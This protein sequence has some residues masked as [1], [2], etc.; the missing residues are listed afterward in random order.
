[1]PPKYITANYTM[2]DLYFAGLQLEPN[3]TYCCT[4]DSLGGELELHVSE[5]AL[6]K[7]ALVYIPP[8]PVWQTH[9]F[10]FRLGDKPFS[11]NQFVN[12]GISFNKTLWAE[13][14]NGTVITDTYVDNVRIYKADD[15]TV[16]LVDGGDFEAELS[17][18]IYNRNWNRKILG[19]KGKGFGVT[20]VVDPLNP[21][22]HCLKIPSV[23]TRPT[24]S[25]SIGLHAVSF[26][27]IDSNPQPVESIVL[28]AQP[29]H[30][31][32]IVE[33]G[34]VSLG[35]VTVTK[36]HLLYFPPYS[37][38]HYRCQP[39]AEALYYWLTVDG[40]DADVLFAECGLTKQCV[41][42]ISNP[43]SL[44][45]R[46][47]EMLRVNENGLLQ[48]YE[49][50]AHLQLLFT[51]LQRQVAPIDMNPRHREQLKEIVH[52]IERYSERPI[53]N[54][55]LAQK[56][57][58]SENYFIT[59]FKQYTGDTPQE[60]RRKILVCR[61]CNLLETTDLSIQEISYLLGLN[62]PMYFSRL[63]RKI[64]GVSPL[65]YRKNLK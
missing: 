12:Y 2:M 55:A 57:S 35:A 16:Q 64:Q 9:T 25:P 56:C 60:F 37:T 53:S 5:Y 22:N 44:N 17:D 10:S 49:L 40:A 23:V 63:F 30:H 62:D 15:P 52:R 29:Q 26:G 4:L 18:P 32:L 13:H 33:S 19:K 59:L 36:G 27:H 47:D 21:D 42:P 48:Q 46:I 39:H 3:C 1:M 8:S 58:L 14:A 61:A 45:Q 24:Y 28:E 7:G 38:Y 6:E 50:N 31:L 41:K 65:K 20:R 54:A 51:H 43:R 11:L 34:A